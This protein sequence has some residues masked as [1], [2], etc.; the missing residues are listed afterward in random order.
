MFTLPN[1][2]TFKAVCSYKAIISLFVQ[3]VDSGIDFG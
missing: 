1:L 2:F 3:G